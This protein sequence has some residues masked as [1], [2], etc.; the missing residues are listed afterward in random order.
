VA[1]FQVGEGKNAE[2]EFDIAKGG[3][4]A[5]NILGERLEA[6]AGEVTAI[7]SELEPCMVRPHYGSGKSS[8]T[9]LMQS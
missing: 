2:F 5:E 8:R 9:S 7:Y 1:V 6:R 3:P 4:H